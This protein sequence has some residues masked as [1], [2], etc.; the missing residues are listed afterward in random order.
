MN[1]TDALNKLI[2]LAGSQTALARECGDPIKQGH[3]SY[4]IKKGRVSSSAVIKAEA[5]ALRLV[6]RNGG[7][8]VTRYD[9]RP[10]LY[11]AEIVIEKPGP[12]ACIPTEEAA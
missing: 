11:P 1:P 3:V 4:W 6:G 2:A 9:M 10:D 8:A 5:A 12:G 7:E